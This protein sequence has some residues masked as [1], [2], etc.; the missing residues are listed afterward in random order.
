MNGCEFS[1]KVKEI[2]NDVKICFLTASEDYYAVALH[3]IRSSADDEEQDSSSSNLL[4]LIIFLFIFP[5]NVESI[6]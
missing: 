2:D 4:F 5:N 1:Q 3:S 6:N